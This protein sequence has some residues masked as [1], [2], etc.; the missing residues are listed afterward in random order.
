[1]LNTTESWSDVMVERD[2]CESMLRSKAATDKVR[3]GRRVIWE[4]GV[5]ADACSELVD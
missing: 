2:I 4:C 3:A 5:G 1:M